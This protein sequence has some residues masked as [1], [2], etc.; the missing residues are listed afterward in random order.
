MNF[1]ELFMKFIVQILNAQY[2]TN[3]G[4]ASFFKKKKDMIHSTKIQSGL[5]LDDFITVSND[6]VE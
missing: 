1:L 2:F 6:Y 4:Y 3:I 5:Q